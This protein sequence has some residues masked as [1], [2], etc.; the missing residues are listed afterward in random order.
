MLTCMCNT[1]QTAILFACSDKAAMIDF[2]HK[3]GSDMQKDSCLF[4]LLGGFYLANLLFPF[5]N[6]TKLFEH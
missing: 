5:Y 1:L 3:P 2:E 4:Y 6:Q